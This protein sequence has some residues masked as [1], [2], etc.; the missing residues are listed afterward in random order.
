M[1]STI[2]ELAE[3]TRAKHQLLRNYL[4]AWFPILGKNNRR[5]IFLDGFAGPG[6][7]SNG[8]QGSPLIALNALVNHKY[9]GRLSGTEFVFIFIESDRDRYQNLMAELNSYGQSIGGM[10]ANVRVLSYN[11]EFAAVASKIAEVGAGNLAPTLA[12][13][14]PFGWSGVPM[15]VVAN[16]LASRKC[17]VIFNF[18]FDHVNRF[19]EDSRPGVANSFADLFGTEGD[20]HRRAGSLIGDSRKAFLRD[21]YGSQLKSVAG[22][23]YVRP[24]EMIDTNRNRTAYF[25]MYGTRSP[26]GL[27]IMKDAMWNVDPVYGIRFAG[28]AGGQA[29]LFEPEVDFA[30]LRNALLDHFHGQTVSVE[31]IEAFVLVE[32]DYKKSALRVFVG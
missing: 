20:E 6:I 24:F 32:T 11:S 25:L 14:D 10:P 15:K 28:Q 31:E 21:L 8:E 5:I 22:F 2:W 4:D 26:K 23:T 30:P 9:F 19:V 18:M 27:E 1:K 29:M 17:E 16:L 12:F 13:I 7:Y 3:H